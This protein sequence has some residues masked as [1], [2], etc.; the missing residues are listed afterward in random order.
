[1]ESKI[2]RKPARPFFKAYFSF[3][4]WLSFFTFSFIRF[5]HLL[6]KKLIVSS[7][8]YRAVIPY[9]DWRSFGLLFSFPF[10]AIR[11]FFSGDNAYKSSIL[12]CCHSG[13]NQCPFKFYLIFTR[14]LGISGAAIALLWQRWAPL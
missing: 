9:L 8:I 13:I 10:L 7:D 12:G 6:L 3:W 5:P 11:F 14:E 1:M 4:D 2:T